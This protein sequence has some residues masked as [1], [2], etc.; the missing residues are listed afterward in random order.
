MTDEADRLRQEE[1]DNYDS[2]MADLC[3]E[4]WTLEQV[5]HYLKTGEYK[6]FDDEG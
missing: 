4:N 5:D 2:W 3:L 1:L 6:E